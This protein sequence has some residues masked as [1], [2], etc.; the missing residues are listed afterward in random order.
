MLTLLP[1]A[2]FTIARD[3]PLRLI[4]HCVLESQIKSEALMKGSTTTR[5]KY[6]RKGNVRPFKKHREAS[7]NSGQIKD[8]VLG[9]TR[10]F[11]CV[12]SGFLLTFFTFST[13]WNLSSTT[14]YRAIAFLVTFTR[15]SL[16]ISG[17]PTQRRFC[18]EGTRRER[19]ERTHP[20][21]AYARNPALFVCSPPFLPSMKDKVGK[22]P[23]N[24]SW[25]NDNSAF[26]YQQIICGFP[27]Q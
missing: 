12:A 4:S 9:A 27:K 24:L 1:L 23:Q 13:F 14:T 7:F 20:F 19:N 8:N 17:R 6:R 2:S 5:Y 22:D 18:E 16:P 26:G 3:I 11:S 25:R 15:H 10:S 21:L